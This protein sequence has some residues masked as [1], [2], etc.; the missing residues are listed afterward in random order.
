GL[1]GLC[2]ALLLISWGVFSPRLRAGPESR[3]ARGEPQLDRYGDPLP[4]GAI[5]R[6]GTIRFRHQAS[7]EAMAFAPDG[8]TLLTQ[9]AAGTK[10]VWEIPTGKPLQRLGGYWD[11]RHRFSLRGVSLVYRADGKLA[12]CDGGRLSLLDATSLNATKELKIE[13]W[14]GAKLSPR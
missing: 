1:P 9:D 6:L 4:R 13:V 3:E 10:I 8:K 14:L 7:I 11:F 2:A 5:G 12:A